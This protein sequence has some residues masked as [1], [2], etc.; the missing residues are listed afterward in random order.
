MF[1]VAV[2]GAEAAWLRGDSSAARAATDGALDIATRIGASDRVVE[3]QAWRRRAGVDEA[4]LADSSDPYGLELSGDA[5]AAAD[6]W[7]ERARPYEAALARADIGT[8]DSL[9]MALSELDAL[10]ARAAA[11][12]VSHRLRQLGGRDIP[13]GPRRTTRANAGGLTVRE[14][15]VAALVAA[16]LRNAD[17]AKRLHV[18]RRTVDHHVSSILRKLHARTRGEAVAEATRL[19]L[20]QDR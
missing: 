11:T 18:S 7:A 13:R 10:G 15:E 2:A 14:S 6:A 8:E 19:G 17:I 20:L 12:V 4:A 9:R 16:G 1:P 3:L 5:Q